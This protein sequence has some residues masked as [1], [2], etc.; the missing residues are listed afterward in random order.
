[1]KTMIPRYSAPL[2]F[3][4]KVPGPTPQQQEKFQ[5]F[6]A[7]NADE[8]LKIADKIM[9]GDIYNNVNNTPRYQ[10]AILILDKFFPSAKAPR[11]GSNLSLLA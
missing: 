1:M 4:G 9:S 10:M 6:L 2:P 8:A 5:N 7:Q 11:Q 3:S